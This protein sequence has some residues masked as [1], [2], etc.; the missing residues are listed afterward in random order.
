VAEPRA[1]RHDMPAQVPRPADHQDPA[2][3]RR[4]PAGLIVNYYTVAT[5]Q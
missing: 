5:G 2:L 3:L 4:H 1:R